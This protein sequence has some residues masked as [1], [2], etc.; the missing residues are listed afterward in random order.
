MPSGFLRF[1]EGFLW[2]AATASYQIEGAHDADGKGESIWDRFSHTP[3]KVADGGTGDVACDHYHLYRQDIGLMR[4]LGLTA[5]RFSISWPRVYPTGRGQVNPAGLDF[6]DRLVDG[7]LAAGV[8]PFATLYHWDLPQ[9]LQ[10]EGGWPNRSTAYAF[11][12][13]VA[14]VGRRLGDRVKH[15]I[16]HNE[17]WCTAYL[18]YYTGEHAP[19]L[20]DLAAAIQATHTLLLSHGEAAKALR[21]VGGPGCQVGIT[22]NLGPA[23]PTSDA[24]EDRAAAR[25]QDGYLNRWFLDPVFLGTYPEDMLALYSRLA[26]RIEPGDLDAI[27]QPLDFLGV[28]FYSRSVVKAD[29]SAGFFQMAASPPRGPG[30][31]YTAMDWEVYPEALY[32][33]LVR[34]QADYDAPKLYITENGAAYRDVPGPD[35]QVDDPDRLSYLRRHFVQCHRAIQARVPLAGYFVWTLVDNFEWAWGYTRR[36]GIVYDDFPTQRRTVK[37]SGRF[38]RQVIADNGL[39]P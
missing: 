22:L 9:A 18:G 11:R 16:T 17:P 6:Y 23:H 15:W 31:E 10:E 33:L 3:G 1:P 35:G 29:P 26:P 27:R 12:D 21:E 24:D 30:H 39:Q 7:L 38:Y 4:E 14:T 32:E 36:F 8:Q 2:G 28:N 13:Y 37:S 5:Y 25:R 34:L 19:G 20:R